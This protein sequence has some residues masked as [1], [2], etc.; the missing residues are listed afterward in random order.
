[1]SGA[2]GAARTKMSN[3]YSQQTFDEALNEHQ[4]GDTPVTDQPAATSPD[5]E[6]TKQ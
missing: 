4:N 3:S 6:K 2:V 5:Q 1:M